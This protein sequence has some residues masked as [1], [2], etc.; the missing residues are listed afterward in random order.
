M[1][2]YV[3]DAFISYSHRDLNWARWLQRRLEG[4]RIPRDLCEL[5]KERRHLRVFRDQTDLAG[6]ELQLA[7]QKELRASR[8][9]IVICSPASAASP[10][11]NDEVSFFR[12]L[13]R[14]E[15]IIPFIVAGEPESDDEALEC[16]PPALRSDK[17]KHPLG[18]NV[19]EIGKN[20]AFLK[21]MAI[22][23]DL[24]FNRLV[25]RDKQR[26]RRTVMI[27][28][29]ITA[30]VAAFAAGLIWRNVVISRK[31][32][33]LSYDIYGAALVSLA[34]KDEIEAADVEFLRV[35]A[36][37][38]NAYAA[39]LLA[40]CYQ[41]GWGIGQDPAQALYWFTRAA[42][43]GDP[44]AMVAVAN[45]YWNGIGTET[46]FEQAFAWNMRAAEAGESGAMLN[47]GI[48]YEQG[49]GVEKDEA[50]ALAWYR[51]AAE[52]GNELGMYN[53]ALCYRDGI[54]TEADLEQAF[55][56]IKKLAET[57]NSEA[58]YNLGLMYQY[59]FG[60]EEDPRQA[61]LCYRAAA[62]AG[63][64]D[65]QY[66]LGWCIENHYG[67]ED[68]ALEWYLQAAEAGSEEAAQAVERL[69]QEQAATSD[70]AAEEEQA[71]HDG[72][73]GEQKP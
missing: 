56:W 18:A 44:T 70:K 16:Y 41:K 1:E 37:A 25:D 3:Y 38:G 39:F 51:K 9:L 40:D 11:V 72:T 27:A 50:Q 57:G 45:C 33:E 4:F 63:D 71:A 62:E 10:W 46:D 19:G 54:G 55:Y 32:Q 36:E 6:V 43:A 8:F 17:D 52:S 35:S 64:S 66:M 49:S 73:S 28:G 7:L 58:L 21:V 15:Q 34:Q 12:S 29:G 53:L 24:R 68:A 22:L 60:T 42:E 14:E 2:K 65:G 5:G 69:E 59:A 67:T 26:R 30:A 23:L 48:C 47:V 13:G 61:Y 31:N 20:K